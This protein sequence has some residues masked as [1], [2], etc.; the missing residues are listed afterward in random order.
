LN[1]PLNQFICT[2]FF[3]NGYTRLRALK[4]GTKNLGVL[5][6]LGV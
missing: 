1:Q 5:S 4:L 6:V 3:Y 2:G